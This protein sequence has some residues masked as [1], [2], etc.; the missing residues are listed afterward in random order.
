M[1]IADG[2]L[3]HPYGLCIGTPHQQMLCK[4]YNSYSGILSDI[5]EVTLITA[6]VLT[7]WR[8]YKLFR[9]HTECHVD[10]CTSHGH[11]VHGTPY[12]A[13][14]DHDPRTTH[15]QGEPITADHI[16]QAWLKS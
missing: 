8:A 11:I 16:Q 12:R 5:G 7:A 10:G 3:L 4:G 2:Y 9:K 14:H 6:I 13:C 15:V 1:I